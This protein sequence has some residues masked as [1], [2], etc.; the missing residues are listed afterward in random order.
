MFDKVQITEPN[1]LGGHESNKSSLWRYVSALGLMAFAMLLF[2]PAVVTI[3]KFD[4]PALARLHVF[5]QKMARKDFESA[6]SL[7]APQAK[8]E[9]SLSDLQEMIEGSGSLMFEGYKGY[10]VR[11]FD[12]RVPYRIPDG[13]E[14]PPYSAKV[15]GTMFYEGK[16]SRP[17]NA[18]LVLIDDR[19]AIES[20]QI[21][22][23]PSQ[24]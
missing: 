24:P 20:L 4:L 14:P 2:A 10:T 19:W 8:E 5:M 3:A 7:Y 6:Y 22:S 16:S 12:L 9:I 18:V 13:P 21:D 17:F 11:D 15:E 23:P 1:S